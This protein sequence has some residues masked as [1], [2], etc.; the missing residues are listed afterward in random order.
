MWF[1]E[2]LS[3]VYGAAQVET[4]GIHRGLGESAGWLAY[5]SVTGMAAKEKANNS[6]HDCTQS[7][8][9]LASF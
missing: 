3:Q 7:Q 8:Y 9:I 2:R 4:E 6:L 1:Q 5:A